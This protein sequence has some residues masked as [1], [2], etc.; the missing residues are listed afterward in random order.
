M[1][2]EN[3]N[4]EK[5]LS[6]V[7]GTLN[8]ALHLIADI[9]RAVGDAEG[10]LM[11]DE[12]VAHCGEVY[13][14]NTWQPIETAP[15]DGTEILVWHEN[16]GTLLGRYIAPSDFMTESELED[17]YDSDIHE[18]DWFCADFTSGTRIEDIPTLWMPLPEP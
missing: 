16:Y 2:E 10:K 5:Q 1:N 15:R 17:F 4:L 14:R 11:Q 3:N 9:R 12:L 8:A 7:R 18:P 6:D 13:K